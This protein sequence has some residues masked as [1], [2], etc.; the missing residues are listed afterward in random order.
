MKRKFK[1]LIRDCAAENFLSNESWG[2]ISARPT[3]AFY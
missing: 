3:K 2:G 1:E